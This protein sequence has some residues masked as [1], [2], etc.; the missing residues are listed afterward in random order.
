MNFNVKFEES[1]KAFRVD[2]GDVVEIGR[3]TIISKEVTVNGSYNATAEGA[4]GYNPV[5]VN[6][7]T[8]EE[9]NAQLTGM[10]E[11]LTE[12]VAAKDA[13]ISQQ[14][15]ELDTLE[16]EKAQLETEVTALEASVTEKQARIDSLSEDVTD[17]D[18]QI[19]TLSA[20]VAA[21]NAE[22]ATK[23]ARIA[24]LE[25]E[26]AEKNATITEQAETITAQQTAIT[27]KDA[28]IAGLQE[29]VAEAFDN[30]RQA[31]YDSHWNAITR[32]GARTN[33]S[34]FFTTADM[35]GQHLP[36]IF[37]P[38]ATFRL[39]YSYQGI[40]LPQGLDLSLMYTESTDV[41]TGSIGSEF[42]YA[43]NVLHFYDCG[44]PA[45]KT[46]S[47][48]YA[49]CRSAVTIDI[50]RV[51]EDTTYTNVFIECNNLQNIVI[52]GTI[53]QTGLNFQW[54][55]KLSKASITSV[56]NA[57]SSTT[58]GLTVTISETAKESAFTT[59]EWAALIATKPN[60]TIAL[61]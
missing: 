42:A 20:E 11:E 23:T 50:F 44:F 43:T 52:E 15:T 2:F 9:E 24:E 47:N 32:N 31:E 7:P 48:T 13:T 4:N 17:R 53:G 49:R 16:A 14:A 38:V 37:K 6:V 27:T 33:Y 35:T 60:W 54:S 1:N 41:K 39:F 28:Q 21:L 45:V 58:S 3:P 18:S 61:A 57:L 12:A 55:T 56:I 46:Y 26:I 40:E 29:D 19:A 36:E 5:V 34:S 22:I 59:E 30:G 10:V 25:A 8:Y 51:R